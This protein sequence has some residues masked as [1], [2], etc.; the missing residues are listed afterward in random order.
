MHHLEPAFALSLGITPLALLTTYNLTTYNFFKHAHYYKLGNIP[1]NVIHSSA[2][3]MVV[4]FSEQLFS[5]EGL[6]IILVV[7]LPS[8]HTD[9]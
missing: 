5:T 2:N 8:T 1:I 4:Y 3:R 7:S 9:H 6:M